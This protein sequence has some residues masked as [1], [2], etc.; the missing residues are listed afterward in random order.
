MALARIHAAGVEGVDGYVVTLNASVTVEDNGIRRYTFVTDNWRGITASYICTY[1]RISSELSFFNRKI[2]SV[3]FLP[4]L[5]TN[6]VFDLCNKFEILA[7]LTT[8]D[9]LPDLSGVA[10]GSS[11]TTTTTTTTTSSGSNSG[12][13]SS[14]NDR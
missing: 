11:T 5:H 10:P 6:L 3:R 8:S 12:S 13:S 9:V 1:R 2:Q 14:G 4:I 7:E